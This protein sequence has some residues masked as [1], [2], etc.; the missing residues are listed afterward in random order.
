MENKFFSDFHSHCQLK[1]Q[2]VVSY[3][4]GNPRQRHI[5]K[6]PKRSEIYQYHVDGE[7]ITNST[8]RCDWLLLVDDEKKKSAY[9]IELKGMDVNSAVRQLEA[10]E[11]ILRKALTGYDIKYRI[12]A[13]KTTHSILSTP[14]VLKAKRKYGDA[15]IIKG[16]QMTEY[17]SSHDV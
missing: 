2:I 4:K 15:L 9:L 17:V 12:I 7:V 8:E 5:A 13:S 10:T 11:K 14:A 1:Q 6:N 3:D 16:V